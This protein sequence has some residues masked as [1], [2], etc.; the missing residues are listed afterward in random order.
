[1]V[2]TSTKDPENDEF[3]EA[4]FFGV[5]SETHTLIV[6]LVRVPLEFFEMNVE[7]EDGNGTQR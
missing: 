5:P 3:P 6:Y 2:R 1:M 4:A 7:V